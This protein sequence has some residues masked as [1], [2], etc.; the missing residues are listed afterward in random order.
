MDRANVTSMR[1][2]TREV[3]VL[4]LASNLLCACISPV[5]IDRNTTLGGK[6]RATSFYVSSSAVVQVDQDMRIQSD[7]PVVIEGSILSSTGTSANIVIVSA[8]SN[9]V[10]NGKITA[11]DGAD[12]EEE[13]DHPFRAGEHG[14]AGGN[15]RIEA[16]GDVIINGVIHAGEGGDGADKK[17]HGPGQVEAFSGAGGEGGSI[18]IVAENISVKGNIYAG[19]GGTGG[20]SEAIVERAHPI[21]EETPE[22]DGE[23]TGSSSDLETPVNPLGTAEAISNNGGRGGS[24]LVLLR[25]KY[26]TLDIASDSKLVPGNGG[27]TQMATA[28][29]EKEAIATMRRPGRG[30]D[31]NITMPGVTPSVRIDPSLP[32]SKGGS[33]IKEKLIF[34]YYWPG[35]VTCKAT[36]TNSAL[37]KTEGG[38]AAGKVMINNVLVDLGNGGNSSSAKAVIP[39]KEFQEDGSAGERDKPGKPAVA[40]LP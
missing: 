9:C 12:G 36:A 14:K 7:G 21:H 26:G 17:A 10:I 8:S 3:L 25:A 35:L 15:V 1:S 4:F 31:I 2:R 34:T 27:D 13:I 29:G 24:I 38:G 30:G 16:N 22:E 18:E 32:P 40:Q 39:G 37:A 5:V 33:M 20:F 19:S 11:G 23:G 28:V 6:V